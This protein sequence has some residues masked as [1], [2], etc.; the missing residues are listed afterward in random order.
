MAL[1]R[2]SGL[3]MAVPARWDRRE[4]LSGKAF[5]RGGNMGFWGIWP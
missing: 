2:E 4:G 5:P 1:P 3:T